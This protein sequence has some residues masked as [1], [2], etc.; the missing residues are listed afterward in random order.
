M[1]ATGILFLFAIIFCLGAY[2]HMQF[3]SHWSVPNEFWDFKF[4]Q[5]LDILVTITIA[6]FVTSIISKKLNY[7]L[8]QKELLAA[9]I[10]EYENTLRE[11]Y[12]S[13]SDYAR[14]PTR[15]AAQKV[16]R[17]HKSASNSLSLMISVLTSIGETKNISSHENSYL[18]YKASMTDS[19]FGTESASIKDTARLDKIDISFCDARKNLMQ[20]KLDLFT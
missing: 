17:L 7:N 11:T 19:P 1:K 2:A 18:K 3:V 9:C 10:S 5:V 4:I 8:K 20:Q 15:D 14:H 16:I 13:F 6:V 12:D